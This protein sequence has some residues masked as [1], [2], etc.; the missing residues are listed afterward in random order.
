VGALVPVVYFFIM[1]IV[2]K[3][4][5]RIN[6]DPPILLSTSPQLVN[7]TIEGN[8]TVSKRIGLNFGDKIVSL[9]T[10]KL[11][12]PP[13]IDKNINFVYNSSTP[14]TDYFVYLV[15]NNSKHIF[16]VGSYEGIIRFY[17]IGTSG[18]IMN[19]AIPVDIEVV[20]PSKHD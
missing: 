1:P 11:E 12:I 8:N 13:D 6:I 16:P 3:E 14:T 20:M 18:K 5:N 15:A 7:L 2:V 4:V 9:L 10:P 17:Y 19:K